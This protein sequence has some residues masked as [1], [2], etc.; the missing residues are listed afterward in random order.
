MFKSLTV[1]LLSTNVFSQYVNGDIMP[2]PLPLPRPRPLPPMV[3]GQRDTNNCLIGAGYSWCES[4]QSCVRQWTTPC[5][6]NYKDCD[7]CLK[8][9]SQ[10][11]NIACPTECNNYK[12]HEINTPMPPTPMPPTPMPPMPPMPPTPVPIE[13]HSCPDVMCMMYCENGFI[14]SDNGCNTC[15]CVNP[16]IAIDPIYTINDGVINPSLGGEDSNICSQLQNAV[17]HKCNS[18]C[19]NCDF[20]DANAVLGNCLNTD[21]LVANDN[22]CRGEVSECNIIYEDCDNEFLCPKITEVTDCGEGGIAGYTTY[23][24]SL[25]IKNQSIKNIYAIY[26]ADDGNLS[27]MI[28]PPAYQV[29]NI[30]NN[31]IGGIMPA[32][33]NIN[34]DTGYDSWLTIG[35][36]DGDPENKLSSV[37]LDFDDWNE[38]EGI[39][40]TNGA[41]FTMDPDGIIVSGDEYIV[42]QLTLPTDLSVDVTLNAQG[43]TNC[44]NCDTS[45]KQE[46]IIF[47]ISRPTHNNPNTIPLNCKS[48]FD[49][50]NN[51]QVS[52]GQLGACTRMMCFRMD[53]PRCTRF[54]TSGH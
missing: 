54:D 18:D 47:R 51:C 39:Y 42:A 12:I 21:G 4:S 20:N 44:E 46:G 7:D 8:R 52:N 14:Q 9:Q 35:I 48:W 16:M 11:E 3:G 30:F 19:H 25:V 53:N 36:T 31:N 2:R 24:L 41:V 22:L 32:I 13:F 17:I 43:K 37:G 6:D 1:S 5:Q 33:I 34:S 27:P 38:R 15:S 26:G 50:C 23:R 40:T 28:I 29:G 45:W 10:G 49:G